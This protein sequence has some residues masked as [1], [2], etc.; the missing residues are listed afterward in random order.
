M[1][2]A[3]DD[4][5]IAATQHGSWDGISGAEQAGFALFR[6]IAIGGAVSQ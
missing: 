5:M 3:V 4:Q 2:S 1:A 6:V